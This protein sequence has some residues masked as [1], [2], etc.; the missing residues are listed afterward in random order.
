MRVI[1]LDTDLE[2]VP[3]S[4]W[5]KDSVSNLCN[6]CKHF[7]IRTWIT[8][9][10][11]HCRYCGHIVCS[12]CSNHAVF[13]TSSGKHRICDVCY[14][15]TIK[16]DSNIHHPIP[17]AKPTPKPRTSCHPPGESGCNPSITTTDTTAPIQGEIPDTDSAVPRGELIINY[18]SQSPNTSH[19]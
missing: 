13:D 11:H 5:M 18:Q 14:K 6:V 3:K 9:N 12:L 17:K 15:F 16:I 10:K 7:I 1:H 2:K 19:R 4:R 8:S